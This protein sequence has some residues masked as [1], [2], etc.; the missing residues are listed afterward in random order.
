MKRFSFAVFIIAVL[1]LA[2]SYLIGG[3]DHEQSVSAP[4]GLDYAQEN[5]GV[6]SPPEGQQTAPVLSA[7]LPP[8]KA[9]STQV[10]TTT[11]PVKTSDILLVNTDNPLPD[12]YEPDALLNLYE[13]KHRHFELMRADIEVCETVFVA[14]EQMFA[15]AQADGMRGFIITSGY[16]SRAAQEEIYAYTMDG[17]AQ[18]PGC[19][20][21]ETG[22]AFDVGTSGSDDFGSTEQFEWL[23]E[24]CDEY[25]FI[26]RYPQGKENITGIPYEPWHYRYIGMDAATEIMGSGVALE[27]Y[28]EDQ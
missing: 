5:V 28:L 27:E 1:C 23:Y 16:R 8:Q 22:L 12:G 4:S 14:M 21:H 13:Q 2:A 11:V 18:R 3:S 9:E 20:E 17:T 6:V 24:H 10:S 19:S 15:A 7:T 26:L 25:G